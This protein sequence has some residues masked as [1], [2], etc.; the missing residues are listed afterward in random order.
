MTRSY[1]YY[2]DCGNKRKKGQ[3]SKSSDYCTDCRKEGKRD[4]CLNIVIIIPIVE[5]KE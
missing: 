3:T 1:D 5:T 2:T 4:R